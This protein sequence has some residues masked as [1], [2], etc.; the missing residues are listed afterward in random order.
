MFTWQSSDLKFLNIVNYTLKISVHSLTILQYL[1]IWFVFLFGVVK[2]VGEAIATSGSNT[3][4]E[5]HLFK[6]K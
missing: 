4:L 2:S 5:A 1:L 3:N 6:T